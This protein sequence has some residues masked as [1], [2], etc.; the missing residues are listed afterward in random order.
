M[1]PLDRDNS[2]FRRDAATMRMA[3]LQQRAGNDE[4]RARMRVLGEANYAL[5]R[6]A[7]LDGA[8]RA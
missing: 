1:Q 6:R 4:Q 7:S 5:R 3:S 2:Q 8:P